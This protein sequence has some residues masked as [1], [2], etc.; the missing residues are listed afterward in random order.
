[1]TRTK[2]RNRVGAVGCAEAE[3][4]EVRRECDFFL[5]LREGQSDRVTSE[6]KHKGQELSRNLGVK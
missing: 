3:A 5:K 2:E 6:Q 4:R 1:M